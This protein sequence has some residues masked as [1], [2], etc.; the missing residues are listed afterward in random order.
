MKKIIEKILKENV[1]GIDVTSTAL[2]DDGYINSLA[3]IRLIAE[4]D[5]AF[6]VEIAFDSI[7]KEN[8]NS[9]AAMEAMLKRYLSK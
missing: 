5:D 3:V 6:D 1:S 4:F 7:V 8:F 9:V 2:V